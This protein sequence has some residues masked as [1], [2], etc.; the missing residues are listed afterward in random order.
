MDEYIGQT[1]QVELADNFGCIG[2]KGKVDKVNGDFILFK[3]SGGLLLV[4]IRYIKTMSP[5]QEGK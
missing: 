4:N 3:T 5:R 2:F 1:F